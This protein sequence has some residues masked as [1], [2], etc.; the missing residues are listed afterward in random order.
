MLNCRKYEGHFPFS[1]NLRKFRFGSK[2]KTFRRFVHGKIPGKGG[3]SKKVGPFPGWNVLNGISAFI[4]TFLVLYTRYNCDQ[5]GSHLGVP[6]KNQGMKSC[7]SCFLNSPPIVY[8]VWKSLIWIVT[9][10]WAAKRRRIQL[11]DNIQSAGSFSVNYYYLAMHWSRSEDVK[12]TL[13]GTNLTVRGRNDNN[14]NNI[15]FICMTIIM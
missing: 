7:V 12:Y 4:Y 14:N 6:K 3:K 10:Q 15:S 5:L 9:F 1:Q 11:A 8:N 13:I 2:W